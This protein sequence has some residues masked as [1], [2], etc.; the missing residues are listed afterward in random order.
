M[1]IAPLDQVFYTNVGFLALGEVIVT[2]AGEPNETWTTTNLLRPLSMDATAFSW[3]DVAD[4]PATT[5]YVRLPAPMTPL[6]K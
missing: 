6:L 4:R 2:V 1:S 5:G 3:T